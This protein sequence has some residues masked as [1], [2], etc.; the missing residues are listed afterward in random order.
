M[1]TLWGDIIKMNE[2]PQKPKKKES[3]RKEKKKSMR[4]KKGK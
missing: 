1:K 3:N 2:Q 4:K